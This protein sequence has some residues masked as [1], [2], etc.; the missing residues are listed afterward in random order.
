MKTVYKKIF[1]IFLLSFVIGSGAISLVV[2]SDNGYVAGFV[3]LPILFFISLLSL[4]LFIVGFILLVLKEKSAPW[5]LLSAVLI[6]SFFISSGLIAKHFE[7]GA[8][9]EEPMVSIPEEISSIIVFKKGVTNDQ[10]NDFWNTILSTEGSDKRGFETIPGVRTISS[11]QTKNGNEAIAFSFF[12]NAT[13]EQKQFVFTK[14]KSSPIV[15]QLLE[16]QSMQEWNANSEKTTPSS[17]SNIFKQ[18]VSKDST[19]SK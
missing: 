7:I 14:V 19:N 12:P 13:E 5:I 9:R 3:F 11:L 8:Y 18:D 16:N 4:I 10:V 17:N 2:R 1:L 6:P 15:Y